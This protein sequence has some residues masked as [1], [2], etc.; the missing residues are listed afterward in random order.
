MVASS[1]APG[2]ASI[3]SSPPLRNASIHQGDDE[4]LLPR[5][6]VR[7]LSSGLAEAC[8]LWL[9]PQ[10]KPHLSGG[11]AATDNCRLPCQTL[12]WRRGGIAAGLP[13][14]LPQALIETCPLRVT[15]ETRGPCHSALPRHEAG[16]EQEEA[17]GNLLQQSAGLWL[18]NQSPSTAGTRAVGPVGQKNIW[19][20]R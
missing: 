16:S 20:S 19:S 14:Q 2:S 17:W 18:F 5:G 9:E 15:A 13:G 4:G 11:S 3:A 10:T 1:L 6:A 7:L 12:A 8:C